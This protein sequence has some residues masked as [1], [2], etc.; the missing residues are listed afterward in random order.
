VLGA[1]S[2]LPPSSFLVFQFLSS[3]NRFFLHK[4]LVGTTTQ[5]RRE[6]VQGVHAQR[7][8]D[9]KDDSAAGDRRG[10]ALQIAPAFRT[11]SLGQLPRGV[12]WC[13]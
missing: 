9:G 2:A 8:A 3:V 1:F 12:S 6:S 10:R 4:N 13:L 7:D 5:Q 11:I